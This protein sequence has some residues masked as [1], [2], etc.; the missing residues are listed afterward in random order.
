MER[1]ADSLRKLVNESLALEIEA[2]KDAGAVAF[3]ARALVQATVPHKRVD[4]IRFIRIDGALHL[5][6]VALQSDIGLPYGNVPR[7]LM[8]WVSTEAVRTKSPV[9]VLV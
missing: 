3:M 7:L 1:A 5:E 6:M 4:D 8:A 9:L 2:A